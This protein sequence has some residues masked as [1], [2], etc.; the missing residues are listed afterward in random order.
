VNQRDW[1]RLLTQ[2]ERRV[3]KFALAD[4]DR[5]LAREGETTYYKNVT[6]STAEV[7]GLERA[8]QEMVEAIIAG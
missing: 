8:R 4:Q 6:T 1:I 7:V 3:L 5:L 2:E